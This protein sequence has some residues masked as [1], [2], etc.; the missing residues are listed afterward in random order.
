M[1]YYIEQLSQL[2][3]GNAVFGTLLLIM[4]A[5]FIFETFE[6]FSS[7]LGIETKYSLQ[8]KNMQKEIDELKKQIK[9][10]QGSATNFYNNRVSD[11]EQSFKIQKQLSDNQNEIKVALVE[12][13]KMFVENEIDSIR[14]ELL[15]FCSRVVDG[16]D[17]SKEHYDHVF[18]IYRKYERILEENDM[19][20]GRVDMSMKFITNKY[21]ELLKTGFKK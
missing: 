6:S 7:K 21:S 9:E 5:K 17:F 8:K 4:V 19:E 1:Q 20:N 11:R 18:D 3:I 16:A 14:W 13:K 10:L 15:S 12:L 2:G